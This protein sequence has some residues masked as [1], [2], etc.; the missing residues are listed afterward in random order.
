M[1]FR[2][3]LRLGLVVA[4]GLLAAACGTTGKTELQQDQSGSDRMLPSPCACER[5]DY[6]PASFVWR[7]A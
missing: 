7:A 6:R 5:L 2:L 3:S 1:P 4:V